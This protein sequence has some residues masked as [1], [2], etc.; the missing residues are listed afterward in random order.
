[1]GLSLFHGTAQHIPEHFNT[2]SG[3]EQLFNI[4]LHV[5]SLFGRA[6]TEK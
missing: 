3:T 1:M 6:G 5:N 2:F 4:G